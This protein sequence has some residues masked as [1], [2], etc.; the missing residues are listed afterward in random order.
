MWNVIITLT[1]VGYGEFYPKTLF[2]RM[3]GILICFW[4]VF[5]V[6]FFVVTVTQLLKFEG[7][8]EKSYEL[9]LKL[10]HKQELK[11]RAIAVLQSSF[12]HRNAK[13][14]FPE[15]EGY[16]LSQFRNFRST[17]LAFQQTVKLV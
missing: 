6:S 17:M 2:G 5:I 10:A 9:L 8:E 12:I 3:I 15:D 16:I 11:K 13:M 7:G 14:N 4:G 1:S